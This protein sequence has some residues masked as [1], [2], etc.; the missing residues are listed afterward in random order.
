MLTGYARVS[1]L[2][3]DQDQDQDLALQ[4]DALRQAGFSG[5]SRKRRAARKRKSGE[6]YCPR[7]SVPSPRPMPACFSI[8]LQGSVSFRRMSFSPRIFSSSPW[9]P[10]PFRSA[11]SKKSSSSSRKRILTARVFFPSFRWWSGG[12][13]FTARPWR[14]LR[15]GKAASAAPSF[16]RLPTSR[17]WP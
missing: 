14:C 7:S 10:R 12:K 1:T 17:G 9:F 16:P 4:R 3:Q 15:H 8:V 5:F 11:P 6:R 2:D 13:R